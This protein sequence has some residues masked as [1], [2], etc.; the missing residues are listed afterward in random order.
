MPQQHL[1]LF[2]I[3]PVQS[4]IAQAR[5]TQDLYAGSRILS[6]L[7]KAV[8]DTIGRDKVV[9]PYANY[10]TGKEWDAVESLPN[11]FV[12]IL[13]SDTE[14]QTLGE[15]AKTAVEA[16]WADIA[17][18]ALP[19]WNAA[20]DAQI[21]QHL[22]I[23]WIAQPL[24]DNYRNDYATLERL[25]GAVKNSRSFEQFQY[26]DT[27]GE[28]GR[29]CSLDGERN[30]LFYRKKKVIEENSTIRY[31]TP[32]FLYAAHEAS[33]RLDRGEALSAV[34]YTKRLFLP[35]EEEFKK[36]PSTAEIALL[37]VLTKMKF[38]KSAQICMNMLLRV[39]AQLFFEENVRSP[40]V[41]DD[42]LE[43]ADEKGL[44]AKAIKQCYETFWKY[45][46]QEGHSQ[47]KYYAILTFDG[48]SMGKWLSGDTNLLPEKDILGK[49]IDLQQFQ[50]DF[51]EKL[52]E[53]AKKAKELIDDNNYG[54]T[55]YAGGD[56]YLGFINL[57]Y[58]LGILIDLRQ[59]Y[60]TMVSE[61]L[62]KDYPLLKPLSFSA[63][64]CIAHYKEPLAL[65]LN[66][67]RQMQS[68]AKDTYEQQDKD[69]LAITVI[70]GSGET[71]ETVWK[72]DQTT[73]LLQILQHFQGEEGKEGIDDKGW[74][75]SNKLVV[76]L[77]QEFKRLTDTNNTLTVDTDL[78]KHEITRISQR[79]YNGDKKLKSTKCANLSKLLFDLYKESNEAN[80]D[81]YFAALDILRFLNRQ[82]DEQHLYTSEDEQTP[83]TDSLTDN[84]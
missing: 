34:S 64:V 59:A 14:A 27:I 41:I 20:V 2:T 13:E 31:Q 63:G 62:E 72:N 46:K 79:Q 83:P 19:R 33:K 5:K 22:D 78:L 29:K 51:S 61:P 60:K 47:L 15:A 9:F 12:A 66:T 42:I 6:E 67:A 48:D 54:K 38:N 69:A 56:D 39:N 7:I 73:K 50:T 28:Q 44:N 3:G 21:N 24:S 16:K 40:K 58:L 77:Q 35:E 26:N 4:F 10:K 45:A 53:F 65:V 70:K 81:N 36:F 57:N 17:Q 11:R 76:V 25:M 71:A 80:I 18:K 52:S 23:Y 8:I 75:F 49:D 82:L 55:V 68:K 1:F 37:R 30:A 84:N 74:R 43:N 32:N